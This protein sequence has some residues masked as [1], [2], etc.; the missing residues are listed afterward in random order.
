MGGAL[1]LDVPRKGR[2][3]S[4]K[5]QEE[6]ELKIETAEGGGHVL[7]MM[8]RAGGQRAGLEGSGG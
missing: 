1:C 4:Y 3:I 7:Q 5:R 2:F 8:R 6:G